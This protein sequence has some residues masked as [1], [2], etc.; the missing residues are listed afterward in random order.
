M[1]S[2]FLSCASGSGSN[3]CL[4][5]SSQCLFPL[6]IQPFVIFLCSSH[7]NNV[8]HRQLSLQ[9]ISLTHYL[10][11]RTHFEHKHKDKNVNTD[12]FSTVH[13]SI[14][15]FIIHVSLSTMRE[16][17]VMSVTQR[18]VVE[19]PF[20]IGFPSQA[21]FSHLT[22]SISKQSPLSNSEEGR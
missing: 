19:L 7:E 20:H 18:S 21:G 8:K 13:Y 11:I 22:A 6:I 16:K 12:L 3:S 14:Q 5:V 17:Y 4:P 9:G 10:Q 1:G 2:L 15:V